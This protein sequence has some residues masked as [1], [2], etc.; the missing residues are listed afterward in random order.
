MRQGGEYPS[1]RTL[2]PPSALETLHSRH[3]FSRQFLSLRLESLEGGGPAGVCVGGY[4][5][6]GTR[7]RSFDLEHEHHPKRGERTLAY[8]CTRPHECTRPKTP[9]ESPCARASQTALMPPPQPPPWSRCSVLRC[10]PLRTSRSGGRICGHATRPSRTGTRRGARSCS[11]S[12]TRAT[13]PSSTTA[14]RSGH[15][16]HVLCCR[17]PV[18]PAP[19]YP[20]LRLRRLRG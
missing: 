6:K 8:E 2:W 19:S 5:V 11:R 18:P 17:V 15:D 10:P 7:R 1:Q 16:G 3:L 9:P 12:G 4:C 13:P 20:P 14:R